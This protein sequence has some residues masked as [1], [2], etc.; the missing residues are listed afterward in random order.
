MNFFYLAIFIVLS[1]FTGISQAF[2]R[3]VRDKNEVES[4]FYGRLYPEW[5]VDRYFGGS[6]AGSDVGHLGTLRNDATLL[7]ADTVTKSDASDWEWANS[8]VGFRQR[9]Q[10][11]AWSV[12]F[13]YE[14]YVDTAGEANAWSNLRHNLD[15]RNAYVYAEH[16]EYG[17]V[18][19][20]QM[21]SLYK[22]WGDRHRMLGIS[23]GNFISTAR[24]LSSPGWRG[25]GDVSF[26]NRRANTLAYVSPRWQGWQI[27]SSYSF[28]E[29]DTG[30]GGMGTQL[31]AYGLRYSDKNWYWALAEELHYGW[32]PISQGSTNPSSTSIRHDGGL[33]DSQDRATRLSMGWRQGGFRVGADIAKM[34]YSETSA[35][36]SVGK[37]AKYSNWATQVTLQQRLTQSLSLA[38]S[39]AIASPGQCELTGGIMCSTNGLGGYQLNTGAM[40]HVNRQ[41]GIFVLVSEIKNRPASRYGQASQGSNILSYATGVLWRFE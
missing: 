14:L 34:R 31:W 11:A 41:V 6:P 30:P 23:A 24:I 29:S 17:W 4:R 21:D 36:P 7:T 40:Y 39:Y 20:G 16:Q 15:K 26:H 25:S 33:S 10:G 18:A 28:D 37:F 1:A 27:G 8:Y 5:R 32:L 19:L 35:Q 2:E 22:A 12:G 9:W 38:V 13:K 3:E